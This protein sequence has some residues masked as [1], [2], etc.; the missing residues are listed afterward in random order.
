MMLSSNGGFGAQ[1]L[2]SSRLYDW[3]RLKGYVAFDL[4]RTV[5]ALGALLLLG[6][7]AAHAY[8]ATTQSGL[9]MYF[10]VYCLSL[11]IGCLVIAGG[12]WSGFNRF[13]PQLSWFLGDL[14]AL[15]FLGLYLVTRMTS[16][17]RLV[18][19]TGRWD[20]APGTFTMAFA[21]AFV[22]LHMSVLLRINVAY[23][24]RQGWQD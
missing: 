20:F 24:N 15:S 12:V 1:R 13:L 23:P 18:A 2:K 19:L 4:P 22:A 8:I 16:L 6:V 3:L 11:I 21:G 14:L 10:E 7:A 5:T 9:P 17:P